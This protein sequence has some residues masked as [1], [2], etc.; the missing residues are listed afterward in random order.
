MCYTVISFVA[1][2][3]SATGFPPL[4]ALLPY[5]GSPHA[6]GVLLCAEM[7]HP[8]R[9]SAVASGLVGKDLLFSSSA[10][11]PTELAHSTQH[12]PHNSTRRNR[13]NPFSIMRLRTLSVT[14]GGGGHILPS[15]ISFCASLCVRPTGTLPAHHLSLLSTTVRIS[16][17]PRRL[18][19][20]CFHTLPHSL[21]SCITRS[22]ILS[23]P[24]THFTE[25]TRVGEGSVL[26]NQH[27]LLKPLL[28][29][30]HPY[31]CTCKKGPAAREPRY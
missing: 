10:S 6:N 15:K 23:I 4:P 9:L 27:S 14:H 17:I 13:R 26:A 19:F 20:L 7:E 24:S 2:E 28:Q 5:R 18:R 16:I 29:W 22:P 11:S 1:E 8:E 12:A 3:N 30:A 25:N 21:A 31:K